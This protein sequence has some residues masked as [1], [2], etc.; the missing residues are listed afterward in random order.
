MRNM[1]QTR[2]FGTKISQSSPYFLPT[3]QYP[4]EQKNNFSLNAA[5]KDGETN[6]TKSQLTYSTLQN[7]FNQAAKTIKSDFRA[8]TNVPKDILFG[9]L[10][11]AY[12]ASS[13]NFFLHIPIAADAAISTL[14]ESILP[15]R[16]KIAQNRHKEYVYTILQKLKSEPEYQEKIRKE[17]ETLTA[18]IISNQDVGSNF[19]E[20]STFP[21][22]TFINTPITSSIH[23]YSAGIVSATLRTVLN[24]LPLNPNVV[25]FISLVP[26]LYFARYAAIKHQAFMDH[27]AIIAKNDSKGDLVR[28]KLNKKILSDLNGFDDLMQEQVNKYQKVSQIKSILKSIAIFASS[29]REKL[30]SIIDEIKSANNVLREKAKQVTSNAQKKANSTI[31]DAIKFITTKLKND[32]D[33]KLFDKTTK[34]SQADKDNTDHHTYESLKKDNSDHLTGKI[35]DFFN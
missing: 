14:C 10:F 21:E 15:E 22:L 8:L 19:L 16:Y 26:F 29:T 20:E 35:S 25:N 3:N 1:T 5:T 13:L 4:F 18:K 17:I 6:K 34:F 7:T 9:S 27:I 28:L 2:I 31:Q 24:K 30:K 23:R 32:Q 12:C 11:S 33:S